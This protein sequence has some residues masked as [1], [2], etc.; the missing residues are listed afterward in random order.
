MKTTG[1]P[2]RD[3]YMQVGPWTYWYINGQIQKKGSFT[4]GTETGW[5]EYWYDTGIRKKQGAYNEEGKKTGPWQYWYENG[6]ERQQVEYKD[7][8]RD[9]SWAFYYNQVEMPLREEGNFLEGKEDGHWV[10]RYKNGRKEK[11][12]S[13]IKG[14]EDGLW[15]YW[16]ENGEIKIQGRARNGLEVGEWTYWNR[17]EEGEEKKT[18]KW[19]YNFTET[20]PSEKPREIT[21]PS[22]ALAGHWISQKAL[23]NFQR[24]QTEPEDPHH[25]YLGE[26]G[27]FL[28]V[29][30]GGFVDSVYTVEDENPEKRTIQL[31]VTS[32]NGR[33]AVLFAIFSE[34]YLELAGMYYLV[35][36]LRGSRG[37]T[38]NYFYMKYAGTDPGPVIK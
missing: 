31:R 22:Q 2:G 5:W 15:K 23:A 30:E 7:D 3:Y 33:G 25:L 11:E 24:S 20:S 26:D 1:K 37:R 14:R 18:V 12:G 34:D 38:T 4:E 27:K 10:Y 36:F 28:E 19:S 9:G 6:L 35:D 13:Y 8:S 17:T 32:A 29:L 16:Y 21:S